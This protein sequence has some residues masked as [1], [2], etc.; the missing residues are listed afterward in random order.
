MK[1]PARPAFWS[2]CL[3]LFSILALGGCSTLGSLNP[4]GGGDDEELGPAPLMDFEPEGE[5]TELWD[6]RVG[7][8]L[9][10]RYTRIRPAIGDDVLYVADAYGIVEARDLAT[11]DRRWQT[12]A[13]AG[14]TVP[15]SATWCSGVVTTTA[16]AS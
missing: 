8:G 14:R 12:H 16:A 5:V 1:F 15:C 10:N 9:G 6:A 2:R 4:F 11:G 13:S 7:E 3:V